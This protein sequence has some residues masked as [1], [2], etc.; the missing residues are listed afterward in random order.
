MPLSRQSVGI[1]SRN[2]LTCNSSGNIQLQLSQLTEPMLIEP[3]LKSGISLHELIST[4]KKKEEEEGKAQAGNELSNI[5]PKSSHTRK[6]P[7]C[8]MAASPSPSPI[9]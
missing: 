8:Y 9:P 4:S 6:K 7:P 5:L 1:L 2:E 3:G